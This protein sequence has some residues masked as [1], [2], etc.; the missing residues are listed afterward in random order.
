VVVCLFYIGGTV[1]ASMNTY[2]IIF[3]TVIKMLSNR[4]SIKVM[5]FNAAFNNISVISWL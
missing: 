4:V 5:V 1:Y 3:N 2:K